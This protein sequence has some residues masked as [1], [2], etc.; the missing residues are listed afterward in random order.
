MIRAYTNSRHT[1]MTDDGLGSHNILGST[2]RTIAHLADIIP[3][4]AGHITALE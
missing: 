2:T 1:Q 3:T 4:P